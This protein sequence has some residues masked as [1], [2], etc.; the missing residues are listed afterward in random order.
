M[1]GG[2]GW[3]PVNAN[4]R[5]GYLQCAPGSGA[6]NRR[7]AACLMAPLPCPAPPCR[8]LACCSALRCAAPCRD[9]VFV[10]RGIGGTSSS[11]YSVCAE[12]MVHEVRQ[13]GLRPASRSMRHAACPVRGVFCLLWLCCCCRCAAS[14]PAWALPL[15]RH[16][17]SLRLPPALPPAAPPTGRRHCG[18]GVYGQRQ[19]RCALCRPRAQG[20]RAARPQAAQPAR[21][22]ARAAAAAPLR[23]VARGGGWRRGRRPLLLP[24]GGSAAGGVCAVL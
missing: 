22:A 23:L 21:R 4:P 15:V 8:P 14:M 12:H 11:I 19:A 24:P 13:C 3:Y 6:S 2:G 1:H 20:L 10:N 5:V 16:S 9:H 17:L 18:A 7:R